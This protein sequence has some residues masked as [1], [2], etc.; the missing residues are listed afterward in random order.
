MATTSQATEVAFLR[1]TTAQHKV[2]RVCTLVLE[3]FT[4]GER[5]ILRV[6]NAQAAEYL[7]DVL[8]RLPAEGFVPHV[9]TDDTCQDAV[10]ITTK[11]GNFNKA[12]VLFHLCPAASIQAE[13]FALVYELKDETSETKHS[14]ARQRYGE[15]QR[16][17]FSPSIR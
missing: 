13:K 9:I 1:V 10:V 16:R 4:K 17:G 3:H 14:L 6:P 7:D 5:I 8:W 2:K 15:Y 12:E 11:D